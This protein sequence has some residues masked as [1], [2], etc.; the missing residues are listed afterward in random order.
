M[1]GAL[2]SGMRLSA[3]RQK[4][5]RMNK[6]K[7]HII[8]EIDE[9][10]KTTTACGISQG[11]YWKKFGDLCYKPNELILVKEIE[12]VKKILA[13]HDNLCDKCR[14][15]LLK[16]KREHAEAMAVMKMIMKSLHP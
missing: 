4:P 6:R 11:R 15:S 13:T 5:N 8:F 7:N 16:I 1:S 9:A 10:G 3:A 14:V 2:P 12:N